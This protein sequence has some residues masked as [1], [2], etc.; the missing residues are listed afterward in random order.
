MIK[1]QIPSFILSDLYKNS[2]SIINE[3]NNDE[4][5]EIFQLKYL[6]DN[7][8][9]IVIIVNEENSIHLSDDS[10]QFISSILNACKLNFADVAII[11]CNKQFLNYNE[12]KK[13]LNPKFC[14]AFNEA[15]ENFKISLSLK[16]FIPTEFENTTWLLSSSLSFMKQNTQEAKVEKSKLWICLKEIFN[17]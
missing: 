10:Y 1:E 13:Q 5:K 16:V 12:V 15:I 14:I 17:L 9:N 2:L 8:K 6:G 7:K 3:N 4:N 11:N